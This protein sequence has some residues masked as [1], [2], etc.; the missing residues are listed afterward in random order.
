MASR[1]QPEGL[2][3]AAVF[4]LARWHLDR[5]PAL[6]LLF[7]CPNGGARTPAEAAILNAQGVNPGIPDIALPVQRRG[8]IGLWIEM[9]APGKIGTTTPEQ[10]SHLLRLWQEG[11][12]SCACDDAE[13]AWLLLRWYVQGS[14]SDTMAPQ[15]PQV[16]R[17]KWGYEFDPAFKKKAPR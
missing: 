17:V 1:N 11:A 6:N 9:K 8:F 4:E 7:H 5:Y 14:R 13:A 16:G 3:Q 15:P 2:E 12:L 10:E